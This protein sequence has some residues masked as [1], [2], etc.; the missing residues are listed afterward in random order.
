MTVKP[1]GHRSPDFK[2]H[3]W[4]VLAQCGFVQQTGSR[5]QRLCNYHGVLNADWMWSNMIMDASTK[6]LT[7]C[8]LYP[9]QGVLK[10]LNAYSSLFII[11]GQQSET[12]KTLL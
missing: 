3:C 8:C 6:S 2:V 9:P 4:G 12:G 5:S 1:L 10:W 11:P 7:L